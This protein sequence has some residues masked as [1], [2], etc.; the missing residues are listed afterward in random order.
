MDITLL[1][2][3]GLKA[4]EREYKKQQEGQTMVKRIVD[5]DDIR[6]ECRKVLA[7]LNKATGKNT[8][9]DIIKMYGAKKLSDVRNL[10]L[11][12]LLEEAKEALADAK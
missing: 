9:S 1:A 10:Y 2:R 12:A 11:P 8:A 6:V 3:A 7:D 4:A 5:Y